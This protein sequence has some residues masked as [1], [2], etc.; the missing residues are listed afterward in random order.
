MGKTH[1]NFFIS[2][3]IM[4]LKL[5]KRRLPI[6]LYVKKN[7]KQ[8]LPPPYTKVELNSVKTG[9]RNQNRTFF[10]VEDHSLMRYGIESY[11][12]EKC[13][14]K[15]V[16]SSST[17]QDFFNYMEE[18][19]PGKSAVPKVLVTEF[20][21]EGETGADIPMIKKCR[22]LYPETKIIVYTERKSP[23]L[24]NAAIKAGAMGYVTKQSDE[25]ELKN[26]LDSVLSGRIYVE[27]DLAKMQQQRD[28]RKTFAHQAHGGKQHKP[29]LHQ[30]RSL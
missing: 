16:G 17:V 5:I 26:A 13:S 7:S 9:S 25:R 27:P 29:H 1:W 20:C 24:V 30:D 22:K 6:N 2:T 10:L 4:S 3:F 21:T 18:N 14:F 11:L 23:V 8:V 12:S 15:C 19:K 28:C